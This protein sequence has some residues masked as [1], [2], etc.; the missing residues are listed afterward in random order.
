MFKSTYL[1]AFM[2][3]NAY[4]LL[5]EGCYFKSRNGTK[6]AVALHVEWG[7]F[8]RKYVRT[9]SPFLVYFV[10]VA[11]AYFLCFYLFP[12]Y[13]AALAYL[14]FLI[15]YTYIDIGVFILGFFMGKIIVK[16]SIDISFLLC[17]IYALISF[18][19]MLL[20]GS[21]KYVFYDYMYSNFTFTFSIFIESLG[22]RDSLFVSIGTLISF[23]IGEIVEYI[24]NKS[25]SWRIE[26][27]SWNAFMH[28]VKKN[29][30]R[31]IRLWPLPD[32]FISRYSCLT[33]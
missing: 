18:G 26:L 28:K 14:G 3:I 4:S 10:C 16:R 25:N 11:L 5:G 2:H 27:D 1:R 9:Y 8:M 7:V 17:L 23:F 29:G 30:Q 31:I 24:N 19:L 6:S 12:K 22:D 33:R 13:N 20:I 32:I 21:L 15:I